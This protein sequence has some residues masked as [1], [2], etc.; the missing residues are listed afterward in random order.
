MAE[1]HPTSYGGLILRGQTW[2]IRVQIKGVMI[3]EST[4]T[5]IRRDAERILAKKK[6]ELI[7]QVVLEN[8]RPIKLHDAIDRFV[9]SRSHMASAV[10]CKGHISHF[11]TLPNV[12]LDKVADADLEAL[13]SKLRVQEYAESTLKV[14]VHY[15]NAMLAHC[16]EHGFTVRKKMKNIKDVSGKLRWLTKDELARF[17][18]QLDPKLGMDMVTIAQK[19]ENYDLA[20]LLSHTAGRFSEV[21]HMKW[22]QVDL[23]AG[24][25]LMKR[26]KGSRDGIIVMTTEMREIFTRRRAME[27]GE[28]VFGSKTGIQNNRWVGAAV[29]RAG[30]NEDDGSV[31]LHTLRHTRAVHLRLAGMDL[32]ELK[33]FL[34]HQSIE[35]TMI[36]AHV[37]KTD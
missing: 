21:C 31:T 7:E 1:R 32:L 11:K 24:T 9:K 14:R 34:G 16:K 22:N 2:H 29:K 8:K 5:G 28:R 25:V 18:A 17:F 26:K 27:K 3:A 13:I 36:Y 20:T 23:E 10:N 15:F 19:Q 30:L 4:H 33:E 6:A 35:S 37:N 12:T